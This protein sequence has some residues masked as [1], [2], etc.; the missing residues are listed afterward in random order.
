ME[1]ILLLELAIE[2]YPERIIRNE[3]KVGDLRVK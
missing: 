3:E 2:T 1:W